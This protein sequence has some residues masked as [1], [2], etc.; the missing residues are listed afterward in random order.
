MQHMQ[1][2]QNNDANH[3]V[4]SQFINKNRVVQQNGINPRQ[5]SSLLSGGNKNNTGRTLNSINSKSTHHGGSNT[6]GSN[7]ESNTNSNG[8]N[9]EGISP[10]AIS[11][12]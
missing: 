1:Q 4:N 6:A 12:G 10:A 9:Q 3:I 5:N 8:E 2:Q 7:T 11:A